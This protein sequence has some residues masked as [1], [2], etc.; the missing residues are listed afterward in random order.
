MPLVLSESVGELIWLLATWERC[1]MYT[2]P[3]A[4]SAM[5]PTTVPST[6]PMMTARLGPDAAGAVEPAYAATPTSP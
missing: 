1:I 5:M 4:V 3:I 2:I 6:A